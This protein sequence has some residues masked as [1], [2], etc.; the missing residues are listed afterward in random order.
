MKTAFWISLFIVF[1]TYAGY[2]IILF[3]LLQLKKIFK[4]KDHT[5]VADHYPEL[6]LVVAA[7]NEEEYIQDKI[8]NSLE[9][10]YPAEKFD[11]LFITDGSTDETPGLIAAFPQIKLMHTPLRSGKINA[12]NRAMEQVSS[13]LVVFT[14]ANSFLNKDA[15]INITRHFADTE[16]G[17]VAGEKRLVSNKYSDA[18]SVEGF[19]WKFES[20][21]KK[22]ESELYSVVGAAGELYGIR[23]KYFEPV[24]EG[25]VLDDL[26]ISLNI[27]AQGQRII[28][29]PN[30]YAV[31]TGS[32]DT[33]E[34]LK[35]KIRIAAGG[36]Q[37]ISLLKHLL[38]PF[39]YPVL[40]FQFISHRVLRW[41]VTPYLL[42][43]ILILNIIIVSTD[44]NNIYN[45]L[46]I[47]QIIFYTIAV[48]GWF[49]Q[50]KETANKFLFIPFY[51]CL[52]N[53]AMIAGMKKYMSGQQISVWER[54]KRK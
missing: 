21:L 44:G 47:L 14:D 17:A 42:I 45:V 12:I 48:A 3:I 22:W 27:A 5:P 50:K 6:T 1:Y 53:Y 54:S 15:L 26:F 28:Y 19:Y 25:T 20:V 31:E 13:E 46:L 8:K 49:F 36:I 9:L 11:I 37:S 43:L 4:R 7:Y 10:N 30:A 16:V 34:E 38:N 51:F 35:R 32:A 2:A 18:T 33:K 29:E 40:A 39:Q 24:P 23:R 52:M 41:I